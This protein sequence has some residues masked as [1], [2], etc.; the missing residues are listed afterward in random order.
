M[1]V[2][3]RMLQDIDRRLGAGVEAH[4]PYPDLRSVLP[5]AKR[6]PGVGRGAGIVVASI[7][8]GAAV[9]ATW[10]A[11]RGWESVT[12]PVTAPKAIAAASPAPA[13][14][15]TAPA[16]SPVPVPS[17]QPA[18]PAIAAAAG[19]AANPDPQPA[20]PAAAPR[21]V[22]SLQ[23]SLKLSAEIADAPRAPAAAPRKAE[24]L[25]APAAPRKTEVAVVAAPVLRKTEIP[26]RRVAA[27]ETVAVARAL[28]N[29]GARADAL[30]TLREALGVAEAS[31]TFA[32]V[33]PLA[34]ELARLEV[35]DHRAQVALDLLRR[36][37]GLLG[38]DADALALRGNAEQRLALHAEAAASYLA[39]LRLRPGEGNWMLGA[40]I[41]LAAEGKLDE[42]QGW[43][44]RA[45]ERG[46][47]TP[48]IA[49][50]LQQLGIAARP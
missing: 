7:A 47:I 12:I 15:S 4:R 34:R 3:N 27:D 46:A 2:V 30:A 16:P 41:S 11:W 38:D 10:G 31:R 18:E 36:L 23:L 43:V 6:S 33:A 9:A 1:S 8:V 49:T 48:T 17:E 21:S 20:A 25:A 14:A 39:A 42:A 37:E 26:V 5:R 19:S 45:R 29:G 44:D 32:A 13:V 35:A 22:E 40:A 24:I 28:W 50:Y